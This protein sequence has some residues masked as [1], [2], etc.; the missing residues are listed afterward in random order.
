[1]GLLNKTT[2]SGSISNTIDTAIYKSL[3]KAMDQFIKVLTNK[4]NQLQQSLNKLPV[5]S[6][7]SMDTSYTPL[8]PSQPTS[9]LSGRTVI[10]AVDEYVDMEKCKKNLII[11]GLP[12]SKCPTEDQRIASDK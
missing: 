2:G 8:V 9:T 6:D 3:D 4:T 12:E 1:M 11:Y 5:S 7:E 10:D